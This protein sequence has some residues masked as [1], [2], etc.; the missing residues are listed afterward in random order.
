MGVSFKVDRQPTTRTAKGKSTGTSGRVLGK[1]LEGV[2]A[3]G[4]GGLGGRA[5]GFDA[6][7]ADVRRK[8]AFQLSFWKT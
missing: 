1:D 3:Q 7:G 8:I 5:G 6:V 2:A 4:D